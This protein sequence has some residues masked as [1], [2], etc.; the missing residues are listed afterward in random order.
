MLTPLVLK[1]VLDA[2]APDVVPCHSV[3]CQGSLLFCITFITCR[4]VVILPNCH[5]LLLL[6]LSLSHS[7]I[8]SPF[9]CSWP[10]KFL[11]FLSQMSNLSCKLRSC[12]RLQMWRKNHACLSEAI[13][14]YHGCHSRRLWASL[15]SGVSAGRYH[16]GTADTFPF[17]DGRVLLINNTRLNFNLLL[18]HTRDSQR[19]TGFRII[20]SG[21]LSP[22][23]SHRSLTCTRTAPRQSWLIFLC[24]LRCGDWI[25]VGPVA[26]VGGRLWTDWLWLSN[27][28]QCT[29]N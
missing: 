14:L 27:L 25:I 10:L 1:L 3:R 8:L 15:L 7:P 20:R 22:L 28:S 29:S 24:P 5:H 4:A 13:F 16:F 11:E 17:A 12:I 19:H 18:V 9:P 6:L 21:L 26:K 23:F 2:H